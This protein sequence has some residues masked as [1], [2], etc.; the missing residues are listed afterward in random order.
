[1]LD[2]NYYGIY[3]KLQSHLSKLL[4]NYREYAVEEM[5][6]NPDDANEPRNLIRSCPY[7]GEIWIKVEGCDGNTTCGNRGF[8]TKIDSADGKTMRPQTPY[9]Y[10]FLEDDKKTVLIYKW[11]IEGWIEIEKGWKKAISIVKSLFKKS[12]PVQVKQE[13]NGIRPKGCGKDITWKD[14]PRVSLE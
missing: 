1:M 7:C 9:L 11:T 5:S 2:I 6:Y 12:T 14:C 8:S 10:E 4:K 3:V 13:A